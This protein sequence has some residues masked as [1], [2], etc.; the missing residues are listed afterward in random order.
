MT[1]AASPLRRV[2]SFGPERMFDRFTRVLDEG[3]AEEFRAEVP[4]P[5][6]RLFTAAL[7][8]WC[9]AGEAQ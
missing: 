5:D 9:D 8:D 2:V 3:L 4:P 6:P 7:D 1:F